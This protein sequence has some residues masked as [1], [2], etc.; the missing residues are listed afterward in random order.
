MYKYIVP[1]TYMCVCVCVYTY[2][3]YI[4]MFVI[5]FHYEAQQMC[6]YQTD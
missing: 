1:V 4:Y 6:L 5:W 2:Y 3:I